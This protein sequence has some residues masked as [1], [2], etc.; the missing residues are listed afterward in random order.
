MNLYLR[1]WV[2]ILAA[3][4]G[5][6]LDILGESN[7]K[8]VTLPNDLD[9][10][11]HVNNGRYL[12][13]MDIGRMDLFIRSGISKK[14]K[15]LGWQFFLGSSTVRYRRSLKVFQ[16]FEL[17]SRILCWTDKWIFI[18]QK[19]IRDGS[20]IVTAIIKGIFFGKKGS[21]HTNHAMAQIAPGLNS[22]PVPEAV[23][24]WL[25]SEALYRATAI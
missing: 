10:Y 20:I 1:L 15:Q 4:F 23:N 2:V 25:Q 5:R 21:I 13:L 7:F 16:S 6:K 18:E 3:C 12:T 19:F 11:G 9:T 14:I 24:A 8:T 22:P 17:K